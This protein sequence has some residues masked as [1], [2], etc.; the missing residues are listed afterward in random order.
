MSVGA[1][2]VWR[3]GGGRDG[4]VVGGSGWVVRSGGCAGIVMVGLKLVVVVEGFGRAVR[5]G[6]EDAGAE[7]SS[8]GAA[9]NFP[10][11]VHLVL[12]SVHSIN[13]NP[14]AMASEYL[15]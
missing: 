7:G 1:G 11:L 10:F 3:K 9:A 13:V 2:E 8:L 14:D 15:N 5:S 6:A 4:K 12:E